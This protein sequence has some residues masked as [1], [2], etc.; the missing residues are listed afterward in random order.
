MWKSIE[1]DLPQRLTGPEVF[2]AIVM[3]YK[4]INTSTIWNLTYE[5][6]SMKIIN[7]PDQNVLYFSENV[8][9]IAAQ[10]EG[11]AEN[12]PSDLSY[13]VTCTYLT[14]TEELF[15]QLLIDIN[16]DVQKDPANWNWRDIITELKNHYSSLVVNKLWHPA[17][18]CKGNKDN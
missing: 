15:R 7:E 2:K 6:T 16:N 14:S 11:G 13:L 5:L 12:P 4:Y 3:K 9:E 10:I 1:N 17:N 18:D 8:Y